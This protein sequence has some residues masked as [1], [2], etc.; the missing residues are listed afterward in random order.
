MVELPGPVL[1]ILHVRARFM[2]RPYV[3]KQFEAFETSYT[4]VW[5]IMDIPLLAGQSSQPG[6]T[7][8]L[9]PGQRQAQVIL[10]PHD[11]ALIEVGF[12]IYRNVRVERS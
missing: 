12:G 2:C 11:I 8:S 5:L 3:C 9:G 10:V 6:I 4:S 7:P 1:A